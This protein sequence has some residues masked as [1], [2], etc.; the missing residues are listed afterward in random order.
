MSTL[1][2]NLSFILM[3]T[4]A[5]E[6][7]FHAD[8]IAQLQN[9]HLIAAN[10]ILLKRVRDLESARQHFVYEKP[11]VKYEHYFACKVKKVLEFMQQIGMVD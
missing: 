9:D 3:H 5:D 1:P 2:F 4:R 6:L 7:Y 8:K 10:V 11:S